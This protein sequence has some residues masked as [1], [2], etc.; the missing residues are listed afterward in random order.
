MAKKQ[1]KNMRILT[2][3][4]RIQNMSIDEFVEELYRNIPDDCDM[5]FMFGSWRT[6]DQTKEYLNSE[7]EV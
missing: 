3:Y 7:C 6:R 5:Q 2:N 1:L 4:D